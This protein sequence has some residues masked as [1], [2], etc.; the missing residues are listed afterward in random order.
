VIRGIAAGAIL[1]AFV[2]ACQTAGPIATR[3]DAASS[4]VAAA[5]DEAPPTLGAPPSPTPP[6]ETSA[7]T[8]DPT[9]LAFLPE[10]V[11]GIPMTES[12]DEAAQALDDPS[13]PKI[14]TS[15][16]AAVAV[17]A[18]SGNLV[19][20]WVVRLRPDKFT[21]EIYRQWRDSYDEG[22][23]SG[24]GGKTGNAEATMDDRTVYVGSC[25]QGLHTYHV[26]LKDQ[27]VL[28]S[29]SAIGDARFGELLMD[30]LRLPTGTPS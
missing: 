13:L 11:N 22:A 9:A 20:A 24:A 1:V 2:A 28:I 19:Y 26:W 27:G 14:A 17:D 18:G 25:V 21:D 29:A 6:D 16:D 30:D 15:V 5:T 3:G 12:I 23:C 8:L 4:G 7:V 10:A